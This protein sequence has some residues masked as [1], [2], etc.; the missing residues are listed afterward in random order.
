MGGVL[1]SV[2]YP[3]LK[4][5]LGLERTGLLGMFLLVSTSTLSV[6]SIFIPGSPFI[7]WI[8]NIE[9]EDHDKSSNVAHVTVLMTGI[10]L[11]RFGLWIVDLTITQILQE[12]V[13]E[14]RRGVI[15]GVQDSLNNSMDLLKC[16]LVILLPDA[17]D[18]GC[19]IILSYV[20]I[21]S[22]WLL[23]AAFSRQQRGHLFHSATKMNYLQAPIGHFCLNPRINSPHTTVKRKKYLGLVAIKNTKTILP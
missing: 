12:R 18:F 7:N 8:S 17:K 4:K 23:Y 22:G 14:E 11:A 19:L 15:N 6:V 13:E 9:N 1:G 20:S 21:S 2:A 16:I 5:R 3:L 10:I